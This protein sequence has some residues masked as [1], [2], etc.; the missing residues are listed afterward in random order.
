MSYAQR[1]RG[2]SFHAPHPPTFS[3][4][5]TL[6]KSC[7]S[8]VLPTYC[9]FF[10]EHWASTEH[11]LSAQVR[12]FTHVLTCA[13]TDMLTL[14]QILTHTDSYP[15][16]TLTVTH[17]DSYIHRHTCMWVHTHTYLTP[18]SYSSHGFN[19]SSSEKSS[20]ATMSTYIFPPAIPFHCTL[21]LYFT[22]SLSFCCW[23][24]LIL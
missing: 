9:S 18:L 5:C 4:L 12:A 16:L 13:H 14:T 19:I 1:T 24:S 8:Q 20:Q 2:I 17:L 23:V 6:S 22:S 11:P 10:L 3:G 15:T 7:P 21:L